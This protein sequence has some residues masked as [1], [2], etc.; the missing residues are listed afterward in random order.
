MGAGLGDV[1]V[2]GA[3]GVGVAPVVV[4]GF[5]VP[6]GGN[7]CPPDGLTVVTLGAVPLI[8]VGT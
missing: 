7:V 2:F 4:V 8:G 6:P 3:V 5:G 1:L